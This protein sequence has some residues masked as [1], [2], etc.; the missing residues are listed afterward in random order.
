MDS[1]LTDDHGHAE[2]VE[3]KYWHRHHLHSRKNGIRQLI[4][5][6]CLSFIYK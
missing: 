5:V 1:I 3:E 2:E 4:S 6:E